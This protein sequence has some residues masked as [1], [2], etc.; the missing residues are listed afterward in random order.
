MCLYLYLPNRTAAR[1]KAWAS[2]PSLAGI[3][4]SNPAGAWMLVCCE[5][6]VLS[7]RSFCIR[8][9]THPEESYVVCLECALETSSKRPRPTGAV[10]PWGRK[11]WYLSKVWLD[12]TYVRRCVGRQ[13]SDWEMEIFEQNGIAASKLIGANINSSFGDCKE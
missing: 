8:L 11:Y 7:G 2:G 10:E 4:G 9:I 13:R 5:W 3:A 6:C 1:S 12:A